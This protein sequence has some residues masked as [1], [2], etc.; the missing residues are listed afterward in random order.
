MI[1]FHFNSF[2]NDIEDGLSATVYFPK[3]N[4]RCRY[5]Y[6]LRGL[7]NDTD[8]L[9]LDQIKEQISKLKVNG[10]C[11][12]DYI[13]FSGGECT[14]HYKELKEL[15]KYS[16]SLG[17]KIALYTNGI[18]NSK[19]LDDLYNEVKIDFTSIDFKIW[20]DSTPFLIGLTPETY[21]KKLK[22]TLTVVSKY[23]PY[24]L[25]TVLCKLSTSLKVNSYFECFKTLIE[26]TAQKPKSLHISNV[27]INK[28]NY[29]FTE[30]DRLHESISEEELECFTKHIE[31]F[32]KSNG[33]STKVYKHYLNN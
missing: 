6:N 19:L 31:Q 4:L 18:D 13:V 12:V 24:S 29:S 5:C 3:C 22:T 9:T 10:I 7:D 17:F 21:L 2:S 32:I 26:D 8:S 14:L 16:K 11:R 30:E 27:I 1:K 23:S 33:I 28:D 15:I 25:R 20:S